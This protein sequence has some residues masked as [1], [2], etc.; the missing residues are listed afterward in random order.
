MSKIIGFAFLFVVFFPFLAAISLYILGTKREKA[1]DGLI[2]AVTA[3]ELVFAAVLLAAPGAALDIPGLCW[4]GLHFRAEGFPAL[5]AVLAAFLW[6]ATALVSPEYFA[7]ARDRN[8]YY[9]FYLLTLG[10]LEGVFL[11]AD[12]GTTFVFFEVMS[13]TSYVWVAQN[14]TE[15]A[16]AA[17]RVYLAVAVLGGLVLL[18]GL[19][20]IYD[21]F[22]TLEF[23][24]L[25]TAGA[26][27][28]LE[29]TLLYAAGCC[30]LFGFGAK[31]GMFP[32]HIWLPMAHPVAPAPASALLS[33][34]LTKSGV[35]GVLAVTANLFFGDEQ[36]GVLVLILATITMVGGA[37]LAV[38]S[39]DLKRTLACSSMSQIGFILVGVGMQALLGHENILAV[40]G[41]VLHMFN[42]SVI[43]LVLF[44]AAG[45]VYLNTHSLDLDKVRGFGRGKPWLLVCFLVAALSIGGI[46]LWSGYIS[47]T[48]LH[49]GIVEY[50]HVGGVWAPLCRVV[51]IIFL[52]S[53][54]LTVA[55]MTNLFV[56]L[57]IDK[58]EKETPG[59]YMGAPTK[60]V[61]ALGSAL[62]L[63]GGAL[64][65]LT[66]E[67]IAA[68]AEVFLRGDSTAL[69]PIHYFSLENL[70]GAVISLAVGAA[71]YFLIMR[72]P[73]LG[74]IA[75]FINT[76]RLGFSKVFFAAVGALTFIL[77]M[78]TR[79]A[80]SLG[81]WTAALIIKIVFFRA[82]RI[83]TPRQH[84]TYGRDKQEHII[85]K[86]FSFDLLLAGLGLLAIILYLLFQSRAAIF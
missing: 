73:V 30:A 76:F 47:K 71:V 75:G 72:R 31:A 84:D 4:L 74:R 48:L 2:L 1:R 78:L 79:T 35:F 51:E 63:L 3:A 80:A 64:P 37:V 77:S 23:A 14:E 24:A 65:H 83:V 49:E 42:H 40:W 13:F 86:T 11:S 68:A 19:Y 29:K 85:E 8:R 20:L 52:A 41:T 66:M 18:M 22:G 5:M 17:A 34:I 69:H 61:L 53:G 70:K 27:S 44:V 32:L 33:G 9:L 46:P 39:R 82:P 60:A 59:R 58:P 81:D 21:L 12:L 56:T 26:L 57:F 43:K 36:W 7:H 25:R 50:I 55:Y 28:Q 62:L 45:V 38:I 15:E 6:L 10:A 54:G 67:K 16:L